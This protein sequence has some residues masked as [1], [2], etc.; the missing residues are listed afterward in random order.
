M[1]VEFINSKNIKYGI[2]GHAGIG[3]IH[4]HSGFVQDDSAG[5]AVIC[6]ILK[7]ACNIDT[8]IKNVSANINTGE[9]TITTYS[10]GCGTVTAR[11]GIT[12]YEI[13]I[14]NKA[15]DK[16]GVYTQ[17]NAITLFGRMYGQG[18]DEVPVAFQGALALAVLDSFKKH[19]PNAKYMKNKMD[20]KYDTV[21]GVSCN[22]N[23]IPCSLLL[24]I[25]GTNGGIGPDE[26]YEGNINLNE[27]G[28]VMEELSLNH[29][30]T[31]IVE[32]KA[33]NKSFKE[34]IKENTFLIRA[35][36]NI[37]NLELASAL[38]K[39]ANKLHLPIIFAD[40]IM[41]LKKDSMKQSTI[42]F[43]NKI[44]DLSYKLKESDKAMD[45]VLIVSEMAK[46]I[47]EDAGGITFMSNSIH[48]KYRG[49]GILQNN[50]CVLSMICSKEYI[51][52]M[53][54]PLIN[55]KDI[56]DYINIIFNAINNMEKNL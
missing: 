6:D 8:R 31:I 1:V 49:A 54:I 48:N 27:K 5:F 38:E 50:S 33:Y 29:V 51:D 41:P 14:M 55:E 24:V 52:Y 10:A 22:I 43:A 25:N 21:L 9:I 18:V 37:D 45:K 42:D 17:K 39:S 53:K 7:K 2:V 56:E 47:S 46:L 40:N 30:P 12:P 19:I 3:H 4:S 44:I 20:N 15:V 16:E 34:K 36:K 13:E 26:D 28:A 23:N 35:E 32:S 11:R